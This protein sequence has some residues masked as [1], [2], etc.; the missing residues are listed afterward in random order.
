MSS[1][2]KSLPWCDIV[3]DDKAILLQQKW[4]YTW[5]SVA[6]VGGWTEN[7]KRAF[8]SRAE[9]YIL[10]SWSNRAR[11]EV[12]GTSDF[13]KKH[14]GKQMPFLLDVRWVLANAHWSVTVT[15][16]PKTAFL[17]SSIVW[18]SRLINLDTNDF[19][20]RVNCDPAPPA[21][22]KQTP[23]AHEFGHALGNTVIKGRGDEYHDSSPHRGDNS[24]IMNIGNQLRVRHFQT[25]IEEL[26]LMIPNANFSVKAIG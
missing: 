6:G 3:I 26:N 16:I 13:A 17:T 12:T 2:T 21:C 9:K 18:D 10:A 19:S 7:E 8:H 20:T 4:F 22:F 25:I 23:V 11:M 1:Y 14:A 24:S 15:K 5:V